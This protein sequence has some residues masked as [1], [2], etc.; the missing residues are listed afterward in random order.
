MFTAV[1][2][3]AAA[4]APSTDYPTEFAKYVVEP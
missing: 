1:G 3:G 4:A 2:I